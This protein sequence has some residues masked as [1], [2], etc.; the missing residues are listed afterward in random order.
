M[1]RAQT[2]SLRWR[3]STTIAEA[4]AC[5]ALGLWV[6]AFFWIL[7]ALLLLSNVVWVVGG[8]SGQRTTKQPAE[9]DLLTTEEVARVIGIKEAWVAMLVQ[10][11]DLPYVKIKPGSPTATEWGYQFRRG[12]VE[13]WLRRM[14]NERKRVLPDA[15]LL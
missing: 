1:L 14:D 3:L 2:R 6:S 8:Y 10:R 5:F 12:D 7:G 13:T 15:E 4:L 9:P 11:H